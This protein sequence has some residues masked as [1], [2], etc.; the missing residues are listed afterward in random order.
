[1]KMVK[2]LKDNYIEFAPFDK[3][4]GFCVMKRAIASQKSGWKF[5]FFTETKNCYR[6]VITEDRKTNHIALL[7]MKKS[8][9]LSKKYNKKLGSTGAQ[10][11][12][13]FGL[14]N[15]NNSQIP[16]RLAVSIPAIVSKFL[17]TAFDKNQCYHREANAQCTEK[18]RIHQTGYWWHSYL[19]GR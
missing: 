10:T 3:R 12:K 13:L 4:S 7:D 14:A 11:M 6:W 2:F 1:M 18:I 9:L 5:W 19:F 16:W 8:F 17:T 15:G